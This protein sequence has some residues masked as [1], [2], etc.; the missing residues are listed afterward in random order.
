MTGSQGTKAGVVA[1][2]A[3]TGA[4]G[5]TVSLLL[6]AN[7]A[8]VVACSGRTVGNVD[9]TTCVANGGSGGG[10]SLPVSVPWTDPTA[11]ASCKVSPASVATYSTNAE[12]DALLIGPWRRC[13]S[14]QAHGE[15]VGVEFDVDGRYY[16][17][18][19][20]ECRQVVRKVGIDY[21]GTWAYLPSGSI[22]PISNQPSP[23][24]FME[25]DGVITDPP[26]ITNDP[27]QLRILFSPVLSTYVPL[28]AD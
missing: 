13:G 22:H 1:S 27:R 10:S 11:A 24:A 12:L 4:H 15:D 6:A 20:N 17:L 8:A 2:V 26:T 21:G 14:P 3:F 5:T 9:P 28:T 16:A 25:I 18:T 7:L 19:Q 23:N